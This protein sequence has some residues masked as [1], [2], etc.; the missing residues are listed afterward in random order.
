MPRRAA[1]GS[2][3]FSLEAVEDAITRYRTPEIFNSDQG[4]RL[5]G[6]DSSSDHAGFCTSSGRYLALEK[7]RRRNS[8]L[9]VRHPPK[10]STS[11]PCCH[12]FR[13]LRNCPPIDAATVLSLSEEAE[14]LQTICAA[15]RSAARDRAARRSRR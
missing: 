14:P 11:S 8:R 13:W 4:G 5:C 7:T 15:V 9:S 10:T 6:L 1:C 2:G 12:H 3:G